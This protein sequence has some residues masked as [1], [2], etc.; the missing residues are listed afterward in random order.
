M[1]TQDR[2]LP[3]EDGN[4]GT[5]GLGLPANCL[6]LS[7][8]GYPEDITHSN[9][10]SASTVTSDVGLFNVFMNF[11]DQPAPSTTSPGGA[12]SI[13]NGRRLFSA[14]GCAVCHTPTLRTQPSNLTAGLSNANANL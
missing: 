1:V 12:T 3:G 14:V 4:G 6:N 5:G 13:A 10:T 2:P 11:L 8:K 7:G 9:G